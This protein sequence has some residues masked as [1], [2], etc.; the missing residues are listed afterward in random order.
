[1]VYN[2][3]EAIAVKDSVKLNSAMLE[4]A[5]CMLAGSKNK[6]LI[7]NVLDNLWHLINESSLQPTHKQE[8]TSVIMNMRRDRD[9]GQHLE[10]EHVP[11]QIV[12]VFSTDDEQ[13]EELL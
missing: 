10:L 3:A 7:D 13:H 8:I 1:M 12:F 2:H 11:N 9:F 5:E 6:E 4:Q